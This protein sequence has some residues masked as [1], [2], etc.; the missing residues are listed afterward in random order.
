M[1]QRIHPLKNL[2]YCMIF[3]AV[4][5]AVLFC[6]GRTAFAVVQEEKIVFAAEMTGSGEKEK[7][8]FV[9]YTGIRNEV[10]EAMWHMD[11]LTRLYLAYRKEV[12]LLEAQNAKIRAK[13]ELASAYGAP[14]DATINEA[15]DPS[16]ID[17][18]TVY[19]ITVNCVQNIVTVYIGD[20]SA[21]ASVPYLAFLCSAGAVGHGT[22][23]GTFRISDKY[24]WRQMIDG[25]YAQYVTRFYEGIM[26]H[27]IPYA[28]AAAD[29]MILEDYELLGTRASLGC[30]RLS[31]LDAKWIYDNC[32]RGTK[33]VVYYDEDKEE[34]LT[35]PEAVELTGEPVS[36][37]ASGDATYG[38]D[39]T[40]PSYGNPYLQN[41]A[42]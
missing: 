12:R 23:E 6:A 30:I 24:R 32:G 22:Y 13:M 2:K 28:R 8:S 31:A 1:R 20:C 15:V 34:P 38:W 5:T 17:E 3:A 11:E 37:S 36:V 26:F 33:V 19:S 39:P 18:D 9:A 41:T 29:A 10:T 21:D 16:L 35:R 42:E 27:S 25:S 14:W 40:D 7:A 4:S